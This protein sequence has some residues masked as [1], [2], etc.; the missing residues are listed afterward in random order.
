MKKLAFLFTALLLLASCSKGYKVTVTFPDDSA[1]GETAFLTNYDTG[2]TLLSATVENNACTFEGSTDKGFFA[3]VLVGGN[4]Y[5]FIVEPGEVKLDIAAGNAI[6]PLNDKLA[7]WNKE[8]EALVSDTTISEAES[9]AR[10]AENLM[11]LYQDNKDNAIGPWAFCNYLMY[12][13]FTEAQIDSLLKDAPAEYAQLKR[14]GKAKNAARQLAVTAEGK[15]FT[16][17]EVPVGDGT[18]QKLSDHVGKGKVTLVDFWASWCGPCRAEIPKI[19]ALKEKYGDR[20]DVLGVA[21]W[22]NPD[23]SRKAMEQMEI[24]WPV[25]IGTKQLDEPTDLYGIKGI[26]HII[27]FGPDG[28]I[29]SRGLT[30]DDL[31]K[32]LNE[33]LM[34]K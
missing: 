2:D 7:A 3:R 30:G 1:N 16:D 25:I 18:V 33:I 19:K 28:T 14:V 21:V 20:F 15:K 8:V 22:D 4:R 10:Y 9:E 17:F 27:I 11:K 23:D 26:P 34:T 32:R 5:G 29:L 31:A 12:D 13:D 24:T 6:S